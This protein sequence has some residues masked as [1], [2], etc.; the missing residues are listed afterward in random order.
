MVILAGIL[1]VLAGWIYV[2][3]AVDAPAAAD[4]APSILHHIPPGAMLVATV[5]VSALRD[6]ALG[7]QLLGQG[8]S[9]AGL[10]DVSTICG[11]DPM[12]GVEHMAIAIP[13]A[14]EDTGFGLFA[15][16]A[17]SGEAIVGCAERIVSKR[18]GRPVRVPAGRFKVLRDA[19]LE[20][21]SAELAAADGGPIV[22]AE[23]AY[24]RAALGTDNGPSLN[25][26]EL[27]RALRGLVPAGQ[28]VAT[29]VLTTAQRRA[30]IDELKAQNQ[31]SSPFRSVN[32]A[33]L[34]VS[35]D[36]QLRVALA[37]RCDAADACG[38]VAT[39][40]R[41][42]ARSEADGL[43]AQAVGLAGVLKRIEIETVG[44]AVHVRLTMPAADALVALRRVLALR[45]LASAPAAQPPAAQP[46]TPET[47]PAPP[48]PEA[49]GDA[50][51]RIEPPDAGR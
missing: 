50:G 4:G 24:V 30:L 51:V 12:D 6:T 1:T 26:D 21:S 16:G 20:L 7:K 38:D 18:G 15:T 33:A 29:A 13:D 44:D 8:R 37:I 34:A 28:L 35:V 47:E 32:G 46:S 11:S 36:D 14:G 48:D 2:S 19:S 27:H 39:H 22:L 45:Q 17:I 49:L 25:D 42:A 10:G 9:V 3:R 43:P 41:S 23:P 5:D 31:T 40:L